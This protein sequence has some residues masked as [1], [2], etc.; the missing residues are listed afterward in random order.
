MREMESTTTN[1]HQKSL[2]ENLRSSVGLERLELLE[3]SEEKIM[4]LKGE[5]EKRD[6]RLNPEYDLDLTGE[7]LGM[8][9]AL[10]KFKAGLSIIEFELGLIPEYKFI[11]SHL[12][13]KWIQKLVHECSKDPSII[14]DICGNENIYRTKLTLQYK[15]NPSRLSEEARTKLNP[16]IKSMQNASK[17]NRLDDFILYSGMSLGCL[18]LVLENDEGVKQLLHKYFSNP[19]LVPKLVN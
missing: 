16:A 13:T 14:G 4:Y 8:N 2:E 11:F 19:T 18:S 1:Y 9:R 7:V 10:E 15:Y 6:K 5:I 17:E 12:D 3:G